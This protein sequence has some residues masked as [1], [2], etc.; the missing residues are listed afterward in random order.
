[1]DRSDS[2]K[3][4]PLDLEADISAVPRV[5]K[6]LK[7][8]GI[9]LRAVGSTDHSNKDLHVAVADYNGRFRSRVTT[10]IVTGARPADETAIPYEESSDSESDPEWD[11]P[12]HQNPTEIQQIFTEV[13]EIINC[14]YRL[15]MS[16]RNPTGTQ[17]NV[18]SAHIDTSFYEPY[19]IEHV[20]QLFPQAKEY[21]IER[22]G[23]AVSRRRQYL[24]Y[25]ETH[26]AKL[27]QHL[28]ENDAATA[29]SETTASA[30]LVHGV[31]QDD[32]KSAT[33]EASGATSVGSV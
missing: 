31:V 14:L 19:V 15:S 1:M 22:L 27:A 7:A 11:E 26:A 16:V 9:L 17:R 23:K 12:Q 33:S 13:L 28:D 20:R 8:F 2:A 6:C 32:A 24:K 30:L 18:R 10:A 29:L 5:A 4:A 3:K 25:W 21:L